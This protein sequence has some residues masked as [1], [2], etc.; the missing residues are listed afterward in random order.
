MAPSAAAPEAREVAVAAERALLPEGEDG[1]RGLQAQKVSGAGEMPFY[2]AVFNLTHTIIGSGTLTMP[3]IFSQTG[4]LTA[5]VI[6]MAIVAL[7]TYSVYLLV[8]ASDKVGGVG[9]RSFESLGYKSAGVAGSVYAELVFIF[10][11]LGTLTSYFIFIGQLMLLVLGYPSDSDKRCVVIVATVVCVVLPLTL[12]RRINALRY[13]SL[14]AV[15]AIVYIMIMYVAVWAEVGRYD[16]NPKEYEYV[17]PEAVTWTGE[18]VTAINMM[19]GAFCVQNTCL[20]VYGEMRDRSPRKIVVATLLAM[21][22]SFAV[23]EMMGVSGYFLFGGHVHAD[24][25]L[26]FDRNFMKTHPG[27]DLP[28]KLGM[29]AMAFNLALGARLVIWPYRSA[30]CSIISRTRAGCTGPARGS[31]E[32]TDVMFRTV[33]VASLAVITCLSIFIPSVKVPLG[34]VNS[35]AG[36]S[37]IF[38]MPGIFYICASRQ[39]DTRHTIHYRLAW[40][41]IMIGIAV[42]GLGFSLEM[43]ELLAAK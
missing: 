14:F 33:T 22:V 34:V 2:S 15:L 40:V 4:W 38:I 31:E 12:F 9:A 43:I 23:Y 32:A 35:L 39:E 18:S 30:V 6:S 36:G 5:N 7:T 42:A 13:V 10:G 25:L 20:P 3:F 1:A 41:M 24:S 8:C 11:G 21:A 16:D 19:I 26:S 28:S 37:M 17:E 27:T 29:A